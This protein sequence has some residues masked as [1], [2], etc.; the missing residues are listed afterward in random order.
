MSKEQDFTH[1][2]DAIN[3]LGAKPKLAYWMA[4]SEWKQNL[5]FAF[6][7]ILLLLPIAA[8]VFAV[9]QNIVLMQQIAIIAFFVSMIVFFI[10]MDFF[11]TINYIKQAESCRQKQVLACKKINLLNDKVLEQSETLR[12]GNNENQQLLE[13]CTKLTKEL[14]AFKFLSD[15]RKEQSEISSKVVEELTQAISKTLTELPKDNRDFNQVIN[16]LQ[17]LANALEDHGD[18]IQINSQHYATFKDLLLKISNVPEN[19]ERYATLS[20]KIIKSLEK[21]NIFLTDIIGKIGNAATIKHTQNS[22]SL[23][24]SDHKATANSK[25]V[26][27]YEEKDPWLDIHHLTTQTMVSLEKHQ[28]NEQ[29]RSERQALLKTIIKPNPNQLQ[30]ASMFES[31]G[32]IIGLSPSK[33]NSPSGKY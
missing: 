24:Q 8:F 7:V 30:Q 22:K 14:E 17:F 32:Q 16:A 12:Q 18:S 21:K 26:D 6:A 33:G 29:E 3:S 28:D 31:L 23:D 15:N 5:L 2:Y 1:T 25:I 9:I 13:A 10:I 20:E 4:K 27:K 19:F 11:E